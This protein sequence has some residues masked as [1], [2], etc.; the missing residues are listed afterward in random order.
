MAGVSFVL[1]TEM[2]MEMAGKRIGEV[3]GGGEP[4]LAISLQLAVLA[5]GG[6]KLG[7]GL[8]RVILIGGGCVV[9]GKVNDKRP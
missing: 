1:G 3:G 8:R 7:V 2:E 9:C 4:L 5:S 6:S